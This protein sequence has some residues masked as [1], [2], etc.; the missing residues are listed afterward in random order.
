MFTYRNIP[1]AYHLGDGIIQ[2]L[3]TNLAVLNG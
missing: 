2:Y 3:E 1:L